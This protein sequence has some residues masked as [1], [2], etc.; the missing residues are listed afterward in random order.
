MQREIKRF[1]HSLSSDLNKGYDAM[2]RQQKRGYQPIGVDKLL[3][4][5]EVMSA[6]EELSPG[7]VE[8][9]LEIV[10]LEQK[11][12]H[13]MMLKNA[14]AEARFRLMG[15]IFGLL[16]ISVVAFSVVKLAQLGHTVLAL[17]IGI[18]HTFASF[19]LS[20]LALRA[21]RPNFYGKM[22]KQKGSEADFRARDLK[23]K[24]PY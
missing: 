19:L 16:S 15:Q 5:V 20:V 8:K 10:Q 9:A 11:N 14:S 23:G 3:P 1:F 12:R 22:H 17:A 7:A 13:E 18:S 6:Y 24:R 21:N 4:P 2:A